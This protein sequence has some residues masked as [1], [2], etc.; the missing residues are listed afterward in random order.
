MFERKEGSWSG[1]H[2]S[3]STAGREGTSRRDVPMFDVGVQPSNY[4]SGDRDPQGWT[5]MKTRLSRESRRQQRGGQEQ[6]MD[7]GMV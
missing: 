1:R 4:S 3:W 2:P 7:P 6:S 5:R